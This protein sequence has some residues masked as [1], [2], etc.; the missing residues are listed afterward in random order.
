[1]THKK[2]IPQRTCVVCRK[3]RPKRELL[4]I[5]RTPAQSLIVDQTGKAAGRGA[6]VC[7]DAACWQEKSFSRGTIG[8]ALKMTISD[9]EWTLLH[10]A[11]ASMP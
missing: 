8:Q 9:E 1:M 7:A 2:H 5:V 6:Y 3:V 4:R 11:L 10:N